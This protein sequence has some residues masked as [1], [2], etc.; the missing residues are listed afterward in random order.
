MGEDSGARKSRMSK[1][2]PPSGGATA[3]S[4]TTEHH[5]TIL[6][7]WAPDTGLEGAR[8]ADLI[9]IAHPAGRGL[10]AHY[11]IA[12][13][14]VLNLGRSSTNEVAL[15]DVPSVSRVHARLCFEE[16]GL[17]LEDLGS[18]NGTYVGDRRIEGPCQLRSGDRFSIGGVH[19]K[20]FVGADVEQAYHEAVHE[21]AVRDGLTG[22]FNRRYFEEQGTREL[23]RSVRHHRPIAVILF[24]LDHFKEIN[25]RYGH[26]CGDAILRQVVELMRSRIRREEWLARVGGEEFCLF[27]PETRPEQ[28]GKLAERLRTELGSHAILWEGQRLEVT[29]SFGV[30]ALEGS[31][32]HLSELVGAADRALYK[33]KELGRNRVIVF[34]EGSLLSINELEFG[35]E[36][37]DPS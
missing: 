12:P 22:A 10:G 36:G 13:G 14:E 37:S 32:R 8:E 24:D 27:C 15:A 25:D 7:T 31:M 23:Q 4:D 28:A 35:A 6:D 11:R 5:L 16:S 20:V 29:A 3:K 17:V 26:P 30:A 9:L 21:L 1:P 34:R 19:F 2:K 33:A 18:R